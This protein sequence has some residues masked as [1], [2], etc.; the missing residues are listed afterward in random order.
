WEYQLASFDGSGFFSSTKIQCPNC[1]VKNHRNG[2]VSYSHQM[3]SAVFVH[4]DLAEV[5]PVS[6]ER[7]NKRD[8]EQK[9]DCELN[10]AKRFFPA[11]RQDPPN[12]KV[13]ALGDGLN[14]NAP[15]I[16]FLRLWN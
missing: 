12:L 13:I 10:A 3:L 4:P 8:G 6:P 16:R 2:T 5:L 7:I 14:A 11:F 15:L 1:Q 9:K